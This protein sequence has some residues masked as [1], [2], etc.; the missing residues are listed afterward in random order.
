MLYTHLIAMPSFLSLI[1]LLICV[2]INTAR[3]A[4]AKTQSKTTPIQDDN[5]RLV[6]IDADNK[7]V[8]VN[9]ENPYPDQPGVHIL[10]E[11]TTV[12]CPTRG[13]G[14]N[15]QFCHAAFIQASN[16]SNGHDVENVWGEK[17]THWQQSMST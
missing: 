11:Y 15:N 14:I 7:E 4:D 6:N 2:L 13:T 8:E 16:Y 10:N 9:N 12:E 3:I 5:P 1:H 17:E